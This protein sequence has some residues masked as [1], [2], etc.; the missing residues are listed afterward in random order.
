MLRCMPCRVERTVVAVA[1]ARKASV[2]LVSGGGK[3]ELHT[4]DELINGEKVT[5]WGNKSTTEAVDEEQQEETK[6][7]LVRVCHTAEVTGVQVDGMNRWIL[8]SSLDGTIKVWDFA[9][10]SLLHTVVVAR[11]S[12][13][14]RL[15]YHR[16]NDLFAVATD[17]YQLMVYD[18][19]SVS[20]TQPPTLI[21]HFRSHRTPITDLCFSPRGHLLLS[22]GLGCALLV[23][24]LPSA[25]LLDVLQF[26][27]PIV[28]MSFSPLGDMI[29]TAHAGTLAVQLWW[30]KEW[31]GEGWDEAGVK[32][33]EGLEAEEDDEDDTDEVEA[34][35]DMQVEGDGENTKPSQR[36]GLITFSSLPRNRWHA[37][38]HW[39]ELKERNRAK[40]D[41]VKRNEAA[42]FFLST[43]DTT[44]SRNTQP[45]PNS[46]DTNQPKARHIR[47]GGLL[48]EPPTIPLLRTAH[49]TG[50]GHDA[51]TGHLL[52]LTP[53]QLDGLLVGL[54]PHPRS[55]E[56][57][58]CC[59][60]IG[61]L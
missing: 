43:L 27:A 26:S 46:V 61:L 23:H 14:S 40:G 59:C 41:E 36:S 47:S 38:L 48:N 16:D 57:L 39:D 60:W 49:R 7:E 55:R 21:R 25:L 30:S 54:S 56:Y 20:A 19:S 6:E 32:E 11:G 42:P 5:L 52:Q 50:T 35:V 2:A 24:H 53:S 4:L 8:S 44:T 33:G 1:R 12:G 31:V 3:G 13:V 9:Q 34:A 28:S 22:S 58:L 10:N 37:L 17:D 51:V 45:Q 15:L 29:A 18:A